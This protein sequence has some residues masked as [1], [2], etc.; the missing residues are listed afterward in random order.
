M[1]NMSAERDDGLIKQVVTAKTLGI[2]ITE[3]LEEG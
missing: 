1:S 3:I 2:N